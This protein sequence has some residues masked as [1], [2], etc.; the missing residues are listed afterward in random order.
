MN[1][2]LRPIYLDECMVST[3]MINIGLKEPTQPTSKLSYQPKG[4]YHETRESLHTQACFGGSGR[5]SW[6][7]DS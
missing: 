6:G 2:Q 4:G 5:L 1:I 7:V 3:H